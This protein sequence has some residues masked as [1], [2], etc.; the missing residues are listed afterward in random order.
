MISF[1][2][3]KNSLLIA[4]VVL[5]FSLLAGTTNAALPVCSGTTQTMCESQGPCC[6]WSSGSCHVAAAGTD[7]RGTCSEGSYSCSGQTIMKYN[8]C[9]GSSQCGQAV[10]CKGTCDSYCVSGYDTCQNAPAGT[11]GT[12]DCVD[13][14][15]CG[16]T[17]NQMVYE[18]G[19]TKNGVCD[20]QYSNE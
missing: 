9:G 8:V 20:K 10:V 6:Y 4:A 7:P 15:S 2:S 16:G 14:L 17:G 1:C 5:V 11:R 12:S 19:C 18:S 3:S 13:V